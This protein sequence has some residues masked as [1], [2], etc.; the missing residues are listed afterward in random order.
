MKIIKSEPVINTEHI[1]K[2]EVVSTIM[3]LILSIDKVGKNFP[4]AKKLN[5]SDKHVLEIKTKIDR[6]NELLN[7]V[8]TIKSSLTKEVMD[9]TNKNSDK[10][11]R[12]LSRLGI[13]E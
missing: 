8:L 10:K 7:K 4:T 2:R 9:F 11:S 3:R 12:L 13:E 1:Q 5:E 6:Q